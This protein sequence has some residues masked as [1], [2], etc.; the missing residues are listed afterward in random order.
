MP[1]HHTLFLLGNSVTEVLTYSI[2]LVDRAGN[3][4]NELVSPP[5]TV[6]DSL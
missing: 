1:D 3:Y 2:V 6:Y 4:S 5:I